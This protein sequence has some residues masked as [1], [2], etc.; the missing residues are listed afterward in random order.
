MKTKIF[1]KIAKKIKPFWAKYWQ[2]ILLISTVTLF[3]SPIF[4]NNTF[5]SDDW[6]FINQFTNH[7][8]QAGYLFRTYN[9][10]FLPF[11][12]VFFYIAFSIFGMNFP[13]YMA[14]ALSVHVL[15]TVMFYLL[16]KL[17]FKGRK[18][19][20]LLLAV[21]FGVSNVYFEIIRWFTTT[22]I[23]LCFFFMLCALYFLHL[24][25]IKKDKKFY[26]ISI[27]SSILSPLN[28]ALGSF[29]FIFLVAYYFLIIKRSF[30]PS[31][32]K[33]DALLLLPYLIGWLIYIAV[34]Y[35]TTYELIKTRAML[36][37]QRHLYNL[38]ILNL[39]GYFILCFIAFF[40]RILGI[41]GFIPN[42]WS[43]LIA[44]IFL[45]NMLFLAYF[46]LMYFLLNEK[47]KRVR[48]IG[49]RGLF[50]FFL[51]GVCISYGVLAV[52]R[53]SGGGV[54]YFIWGRYHLFPAF[55]MYLLFGSM[56]I[57]VRTILGKIFDKKKVMTFFYFLF[58]LYLI[59]Q[60][61][62]IWKKSDSSMRIGA[63][64]GPEKV[65]CVQTTALRSTSL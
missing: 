38:N 23:S 22:Q 16:A 65:A 1:T 3:W 32:L 28:F 59:M 36:L 62:L 6:A 2:M 49:D 12:K 24:Y 46:L 26:Y 45:A 34:Y 64:M 15:N 20:P 17:I 30:K 55:F 60:M 37:D 43:L 11:F 13:P 19:L 50:W 48:L 9:E 40:T 7:G 52:G 56:A 27:A 47:K 51:I 10:H 35:F 63:L 18:K 31:R 53:P 25:V 54:A 39:I 44:V 57:S 4:H 8:F 5:F 33:E 41:G 29:T 14:I 42:V 58:V 21:A 61:G